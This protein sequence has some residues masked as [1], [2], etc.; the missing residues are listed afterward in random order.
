MRSFICS[1]LLFASTTAAQAVVSKDELQTL[2][3]DGDIAGVEAA[4]AEAHQQ[5]LTGEITYDELRLLMHVLTRTHPD[6]VD[7]RE[8]WLKN[9][10]QSAYAL[11]AMAWANQN[12]SIDIRGSASSRQ[13]PNDALRA[14]SYMTGQALTLMTEAYRIAPDFISASDGVIV[15]QGPTKRLREWQVATI[16]QNVMNTTPNF[17][18][19][20]RASSLS[21]RGW[22]GDGPE[23]NAG[24]CNRYV[25]KIP[26]YPNMTKDICTVSLMADQHQLAENWNYVAD[27]LDREDHEVLA[28]AH[29]L[30]AQDRDTAQDLETVMDYLSN[31]SFDTPWFYYD[32][33]MAGS[34]RRSLYF[35]QSDEP[36]AFAE[37]LYA[38]IHTEA[39]AQLEHDPFRVSLL[40]IVTGQDNRIEAQW[41]GNDGYDRNYALRIAVAQPYHLS[42]WT[43]VSI[44]WSEKSDFLVQPEHEISNV[45]AIAYSD[46]D[47]SH[48]T[49]YLRGR[50][51]YLKRFNDRGTS[52]GF[53]GQPWP[54][55]AE[56]ISTVG[57]RAA[58]LIRL[59]NDAASRAPELRNEIDGFRITNNLAAVTAELRGK[60]ACRH[61]WEAHFVDLRFEPIVVDR[62]SLL[63]VDLDPALFWH[64]DPYLYP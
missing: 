47:I 30:R 63:D 28:Y 27:V 56:V 43:E 39:L 1:I 50:L 2:V 49:S 11:T 45:N 20:L 31:V 18:T 61:V 21:S 12:D 64:P 35:S 57:C 4:F 37:K 48:I 40:K 10:P 25:D 41:L 5:S 29:A 52:A 51:D 33:R 62:R 38:R 44:Q 53:D 55:E 19:L 26:E 22:G 7:F 58:R 32:I 14:S 54:P 34:V 24:L 8:R 23:F 46:H 17:G 36:R 13:T 42:N 9:M 59:Y 15:M 60:E 16:I 3:Y 6:T